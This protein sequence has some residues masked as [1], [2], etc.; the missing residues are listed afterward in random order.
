MFPVSQSLLKLNIHCK[1]SL[2]LKLC[3]DSMKNLICPLCSCVS[4]CEMWVML[5]V[6]I[7]LINVFLK[8]ALRFAFH[9]YYLHTLIHS[10]VAQLVKNLTAMQ[11]TWVRSLVQKIPWRREYLPLYLSGRRVHCPLCSGWGEGLDNV[12]TPQIG[13]SWR[14][15]MQLSYPD[16]LRSF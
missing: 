12:S 3:Y 10:L 1:F 2:F 7:M 9:V 14:A 5:L 11:E 15:A 8:T 16:I 13:S 6:S 4:I